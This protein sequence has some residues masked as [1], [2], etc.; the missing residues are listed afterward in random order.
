MPCGPTLTA[1]RPHFLP[2]NF[3]DPT[4][5]SGA[6]VT[7]AASS[8]GTGILVLMAVLPVIH[9]LSLAALDALSHLPFLKVGRAPFESHRV[10]KPCCH[11]GWG[12]LLSQQPANLRFSNIQA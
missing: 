8:G 7:G 1:R 9:I 12:C 5:Y 11:R 6:A 3:Y 10:L 2:L 4:T